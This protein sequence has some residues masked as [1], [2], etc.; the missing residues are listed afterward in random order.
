M[1]DAIAERLIGGHKF[2]D[3][4]Q[5]GRIQECRMEKRGDGSIERRIT[6]T[7]PGVSVERVQGA[8]GYD[9]WSRKR[10]DQWLIDS[11]MRL[12][13]LLMRIDVGLWKLA[14]VNGLVWW[15]AVSAIMT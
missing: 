1:Q 5:F 13:K 3:A 4:T 2:G 15:A 6:F 8:R 12:Q 9:G 14:L 7:G 10:Q 11:G